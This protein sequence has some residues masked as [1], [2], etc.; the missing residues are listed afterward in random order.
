MVGPGKDEADAMPTKA[1][2][3]GGSAGARTAR[4]AAGA[5]F[6]CGPDVD[7]LQEL[8]TDDGDMADG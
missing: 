2:G 6:R 5:D 8:A 4:Q 1:A 3:T 7:R